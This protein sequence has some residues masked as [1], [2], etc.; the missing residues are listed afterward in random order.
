MSELFIKILADLSG[1]V[2]LTGYFIVS[3][4]FDLAKSIKKNSEEQKKKDTKQ[5][6]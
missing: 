5:I 1:I 3:M 6:S 2:I 4:L